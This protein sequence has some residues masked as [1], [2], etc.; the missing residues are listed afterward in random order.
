MNVVPIDITF[1]CVVAET[2]ITF[3]AKKKQ[4]EDISKTYKYILGNMGQ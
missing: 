4:K 1:Q 2:A 3:P